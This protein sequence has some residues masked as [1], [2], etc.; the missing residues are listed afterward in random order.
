[1]KRAWRLAA[2]AAVIAVAVV[3]ALFAGS[4]SSQPSAAPA[5]SASGD[6]LAANPDAL[7]GAA[8]KL[9]P[10]A[11]T[12]ITPGY[13]SPALRDLPAGGGPV[14]PPPPVVPPPRGTD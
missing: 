10:Q 4:G 12:N 7:F 11:V 2:G 13:L 14:P 1:M 9:A 3:V 5:A 8:Q 6:P